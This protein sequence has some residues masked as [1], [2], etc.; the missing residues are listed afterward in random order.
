MAGGTNAGSASQAKEGAKAVTNQWYNGELNDYPGFGGEPGMGNFGAWGH[1]SALVWSGTSRVGCV[2]HLCKAGS[3][4]GGMDSWYTVCN[5]G[6][7]GNV[8]GRY[9]SNVKRPQGQ[10]N[11]VV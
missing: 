11:V 3:P 4:M 1:F 5:Y 10:A 2:T 6:P 9:S 7:P 8:G